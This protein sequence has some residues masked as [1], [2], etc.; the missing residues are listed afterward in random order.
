MVAPEEQGNNLVKSTFNF[1]TC[2]FN[3]FVLGFLKLYSRE[4]GYTLSKTH[5]FLAV[6]L[7]S[8]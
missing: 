6:P 5:F 2:C 7:N 4:K 1:H 8:K 3:C